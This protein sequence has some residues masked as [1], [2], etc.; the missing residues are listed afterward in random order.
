MISN[1]YEK[2]NLNQTGVGTTMLN[3]P[4]KRDSA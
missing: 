2:V 4:L 3:H 1:G